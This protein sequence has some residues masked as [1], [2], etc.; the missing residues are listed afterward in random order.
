MFFTYLITFSIPVIAIALIIWRISVQKKRK[1]S[2]IKPEE[3]AK[4]FLPLWKGLL[5]TLILVITFILFIF[6]NELNF[7]NI[8]NWVI[9]IVFLVIFVDAKKYNIKF[10]K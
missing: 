7:P 8:F 10:W 5:Y 1:E 3:N 2:K 4:P 9:F 6:R